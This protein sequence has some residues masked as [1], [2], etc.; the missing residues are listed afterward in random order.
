MSFALP[1]PLAY[2]GVLACYLKIILE[3]YIIVGVVDR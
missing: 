1:H 3:F 2:H